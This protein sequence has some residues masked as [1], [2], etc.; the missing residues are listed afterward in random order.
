MK[1]RKVNK[2]HF[3]GIGGIGMSG[4]AELLINLGFEVSGSDINKSEITNNLKLKG[5]KIFN[6]HNSKN[7]NNCDAVVFSSAINKNN[8]E[9]V[10]KL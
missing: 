7:V 6:S 4:I 3:V 9:L 2:I 10:F 5:A 1:Y 8:V